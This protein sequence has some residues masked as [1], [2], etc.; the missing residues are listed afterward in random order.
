MTYPRNTMRPEL[1]RDLAQRFGTP[2]YVYDAATLRGQLAE[3]RRAGF[4]GVR[5]AQKAC[6]NTHIQRLLRAEGAVVDCVSLGEL[7]RALIAGFEPAAARGEIVYTADLLTA[8]TLERIVALDVCVNAGSEDMLTQLGERHP[9]HA[10]WLRINPGFG[11]GH[12]KKVNTGGS[13]SK[14]GIWFANLPDALRRVDAYQLRLVGLHMHIGSG[15]DI[16]H[17]KRVCDAMVTEVA[18]SGRDIRAIS[19]GGGLPIPYKAGDPS[20]DVAAY[21]ACWDAAR[22]AI[23]QQLG[24]AVHLEVEPGR[25]LVAQAGVLLAEVRATK[26]MGDNHFTLVDA[27][28]NDLMRPAMYGAHH[29]ISVIARGTPPAS[30]ARRPTVVAGPLCE[31]GDVF[32]QNSGGDV[33]PRL[34]EPAAVGDLLVFHDA[35]A[36]G[37]SMSSNYNTRG[38]PAEVLVDGERVQLIRRR[39]QLSELLALEQT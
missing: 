33:V 21:Y 16:E 1:L 9:G 17:L 34:L 6:P 35:G 14:H 25:Y 4:D 39:Q 30:A 8:E 10:V 28:F 27:G 26:T 2:L 13:S 29:D 36:Y 31:S 24:H 19:A 15:A 20:L 7:E 12:S 3:L 38:L 5:Y 22:K 11:H 37:A 32:T 18:R 23:E